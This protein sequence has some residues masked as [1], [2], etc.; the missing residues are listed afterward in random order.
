MEKLTKTEIER[1]LA[2]SDAFGP[3]GLEDEVSALVQKELD[4]IL[5]L[6]KIG[7]QFGD[8]GFELFNARSQG[9]VAGC[10][11]HKRCGC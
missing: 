8:I 9:V 6:A 1:I 7:F 4:G 10:T 3:S 2:L 5:E 11:E